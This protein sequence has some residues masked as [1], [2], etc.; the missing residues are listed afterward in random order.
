P[1]NEELEKQID[2]MNDT[3]T[4]Q[5]AAKGKTVE[6]LTKDP[7]QQMI[8]LIKETFD[9]EII[10]AAKMELAYAVNSWPQAADAAK[11]LFDKCQ[12]LMEKGEN[13]VPR[14]SGERRK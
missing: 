5:E 1:S 10:K 2:G 9:K 6:K 13:Q 8:E 7:R 14:T 11:R 3:P 12:E 4:P